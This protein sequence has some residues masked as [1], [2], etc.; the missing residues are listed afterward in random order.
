MLDLELFF[1]LHLGI[2]FKN[3]KKSHVTVIFNLYKSCGWST[4]SADNLKICDED[5]TSP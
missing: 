5:K 1:P 3:Y 2:I 4:M